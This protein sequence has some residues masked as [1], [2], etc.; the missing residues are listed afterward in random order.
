MDIRG[1][2]S[3]P[4]P[5]GLP[6]AALGPVLGLAGAVAALQLALAGRY[7]FHRDELYFLSAGRHL[8]WGYVDQPPLTPLLARAS[9]AVFG[10]SPTGMR[11]VAALLCAATVV[12]IALAAR[13]L[14]AHRAGQVLA[15][16]GTAVSAMVL[17]V[18]HMLS[19]ASFDLFAWA[20]IGVL[21]LRLLR[22]GERRWWVAVGAAVG[23][24][25]LNKDL[26]L[27][28]AAA[29]LPAIALAGPREVLRGRWLPLGAAVALLVAAPNLYWQARHGWPQ[30]TVASGISDQDGTTNRLTFVPMQLVYLSPVL[31]PIWLAGLR[32]LRSDP[33]VRWARPIGYG[34]LALC[35]LVLVLGGKPYYALPPLLLV[36]AAGCEPVARRLRSPVRPVAALLVAALVNCLITLPVLP[37]RQLAAV[38][39]IYP[40]SAEQVGWPE[41][42]SAVATGWEQI[43]PGD[44]ARAVVFATDYGEAGA[45]ALYGPR[46]GLPAPY[47]GHM[48]FTDWG[49]P[50]DSATGPVLLVR[51]APYPEVERAFTGCR[52]VALVD[53]GRGVPNEEQHAPVLLCS[54]PVAPWSVLWPR[55]RHSY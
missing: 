23:V 50:P 51:P 34:Y 15:A 4:A 27:L 16:A 55:L 20:G 33:E 12:L 11:V 7:G 9:T 39:W 37:E 6:R 47:S 8:A 48:S 38:S 10:G 35:V 18:G 2:A 44:R 26:V 17:A 40:E 19:T 49:P 13:E 53:N 3:V 43:P 22:T 32:R 24:A 30:L 41:L 25:L 42:T 14:G 29:V 28:L 46:L 1:N 5:T 45:L 31:I 21:L 54:G 52:Q 36:L